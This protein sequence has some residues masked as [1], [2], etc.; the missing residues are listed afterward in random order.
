M[1]K[2]YINTKDVETL[3]G[4]PY[5]ELLSLVKCGTIQAHKTRRGHWRWNVKAVEQFFGIQI[6]E[7]EESIRHQKNKWDGQTDIFFWYSAHHQRESL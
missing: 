2:K 1:I 4:R 7:P 3:T 6:C 5:N